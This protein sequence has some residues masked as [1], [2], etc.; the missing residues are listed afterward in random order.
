MIGAIAA[1]GSSAGSGVGMAVG[2]ITGAGI[3]VAGCVSAIV[4]IFA[5]TRITVVPRVF[6]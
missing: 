5:V 4:N 2:A 3:Y 6:L 1:A